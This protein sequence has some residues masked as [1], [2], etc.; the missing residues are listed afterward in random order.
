MAIKQRIYI[1]TSVVGGYFDDE[2]KEPTIK[3]F[4]RLEKNEIIF[5]VSDLIV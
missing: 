5:V 3:L 1:D 4:E 2:F